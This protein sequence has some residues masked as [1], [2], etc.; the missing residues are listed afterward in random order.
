MS[1]EELKREALKLPADEQLELAYSLIRNVGAGD[2][3]E[4]AEVDPVWVKEA[5]R[6]YQD[7]LDGKV[8]AVPGEAAIRRIRAVLR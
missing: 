3:D 8:K 5:E 7:F 4:D 2:E 1:F 6:R